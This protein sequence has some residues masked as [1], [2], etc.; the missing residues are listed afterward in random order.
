MMFVYSIDVNFIH[1]FVSFIYFI[2]SY[3]ILSYF[4]HIIE[5]ENIFYWTWWSWPVGSES[6]S[7]KINLYSVRENLENI[8]S[9]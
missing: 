9:Y 4:Y 2:S 6:L 1:L 8:C 3:F 7:L 5:G